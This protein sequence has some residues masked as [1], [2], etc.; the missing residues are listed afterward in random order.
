[1]VDEVLLVLSTFPDLETARRISRQVVEEKAAA[2]ANI[3]PAIE[4][5]YWWKGKVEAGNETLVLFKTTADGCDRLQTILRGL[6]P[7]EVPEI[8]ALP[9]SRGLPDYL[10]WLASNCG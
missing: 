8:I 6:H 4:S 3:L 7:Y 1:M 2:C 5:I 10:Q 9:I